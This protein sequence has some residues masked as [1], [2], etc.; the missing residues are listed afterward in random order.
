MHK[1]N[2]SKSRLFKMFL[3]VMSDAEAEKALETVYTQC[4]TPTQRN[5]L[6][7]DWKVLLKELEDIRKMRAKN[8]FRQTFGE[9]ADED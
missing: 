1:A 3:R 4:L 2:P 7:A 6:K 8:R 5:E 9:D